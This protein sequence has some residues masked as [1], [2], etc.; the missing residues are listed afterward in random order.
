MAWEAF[1]PVAESL[2][3]EAVERIERIAWEVIPQLAESLI[4][5]ELRKLKGE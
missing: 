2:V 3:R 4:K 5:E 1:G